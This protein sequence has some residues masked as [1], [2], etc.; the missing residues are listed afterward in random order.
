MKKI[1]RDKDL[2]PGD[3]IYLAL[4]AQEEHLFNIL[5]KA[6][7]ANIDLTSGLELAYKSLKARK[8][9]YKQQINPKT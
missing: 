2:K 4:T 1:I 7:E 3:T 9:M 5:V 6:K 8:R